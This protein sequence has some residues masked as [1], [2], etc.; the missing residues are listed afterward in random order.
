[1]TM[2]DS[3][4]TPAG[5]RPKVV[6]QL[7]RARQLAD[8]LA[9]TYPNPAEALAAAEV[10]PRDGWAVVAQHA[11]LTAPS[12]DTALLAIELLRHD[13]D[14]VLSDARRPKEPEV[15]Q[16]CGH[17]H[18]LNDECPVPPDSAR[19]LLQRALYS[20]STD[21]ERA[22]D[23]LCAVHQLQGRLND[24][25]SEA[26]LGARMA[27]CTWIQMGEAIG[28]TRMLARARWAA[29]V[30]RFEAA[31]MLRPEQ[32]PPPVPP[33]DPT[34][35]ALNDARSWCRW[36]GHRIVLDGSS[37]SVADS[38][39]HHVLDGGARHDGLIDVDCPGPEPWPAQED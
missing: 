22:L 10:L 16:A 32:L 39:A 7:R 28:S 36:C 13:H 18:R 2:T 29:M 21:P 14:D 6:H 1:M 37:G 23:R 9:V 34:A 30:R 5:D 3:P 20:T 11:R 33:R 8:L 35:G 25:E 24:E 12:P 4:T 38:W 31:G 17:A 15:H 27:G 19:G 26:V